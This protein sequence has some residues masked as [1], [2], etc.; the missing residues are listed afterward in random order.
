MEPSLRE[1]ERVARHVRLLLGDGHI[2]LCT[3]DP[4]LLCD[5]CVSNDEVIA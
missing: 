3:Q 1:F 2:K 4:V 5:E